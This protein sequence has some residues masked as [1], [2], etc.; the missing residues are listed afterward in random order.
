[1]P[2]LL[3]TDV[4]VVGAGPTGLLAALRLARS[5]ARVVLIEEE[6]RTAGHSYALALHGRALLRLDE[7]GLAQAAVAAGNRLNR[8]RLFDTREEQA[9]LDLAIPDA[10]FP[11]VLVLPQSALEGL[12]ASA[13]EELGTAV[14]W[15]HRLARLEQRGET[16]VATVQQL[17]KQSGGYAVAHTEWVVAEELQVE[18]SFVVAADGHRSLARRALG[19]AFPEVGPSQTFAVLECAAGATPQ[20]ELRLVLDAGR[21][22]ALWPLPASRARWSLE[23]EAPEV[24]ADERYKSRLTTRL[25]E[26]FFHHLPDAAVAALLHHRAPWFPAQPAEVGWSVEVRFERRLAEAFGRGRVWLAGDAVHLTGPAGM[27]SMNAGLDEA[28]DLAARIDRVRRGEGSLELLEQYGRERAAAWRLMLGLDG[29]LRP[30]PAAPALVAQNAA[31]LLSCLPA[32]GGELATLA[33]RVGL[34]LAI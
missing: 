11:F 34:E 6:W 9:A 18:A 26:R 5:G 21:V 4:L 13:L 3:R 17:E 24:T 7:V 1:V 29:R 15:S 16:V 28:S 33:G 20:D 23:L 32:T 19:V 22:S 14:R 2:G 27:Q 12:L 25:G 31:R 30:G 10:R 8:L